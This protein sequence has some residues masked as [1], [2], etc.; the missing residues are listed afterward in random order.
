MV[1]W[2]SVRIPAELKEQV[3]DLIK[4]IPFWASPDEFV[5]DAVREKVNIVQDSQDK[6]AEANPQ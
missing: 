4:R 3:K 5:R 1:E 6:Q 2:S